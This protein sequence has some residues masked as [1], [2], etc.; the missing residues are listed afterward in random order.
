MEN[1]E[2]IKADLQKSIDEAGVALKTK[3]SNAEDL[4]QK[5]FDKADAVLKSL[6]GVLS[7]EDAQKMQSQL[8]KLD[9]AIQKSAVQK[10]VNEESFKD[11]FMKAYAPVQKEIERMKSAGERL[12]AP[13]TFEIQEKTVGTI[14]LAS[15]L[16]NVSSS[17]QVTI[18][19]FTGVVSP[20]RQR[21]LTYLQ[22]VSV[23]AIGTQYAVWVEEY[24]QEGVPVFIGEGIEK[25]Q[26][27]VQYKEQRAKVN[28]IGVHMKVTTEMLE[29]A[30][31][32]FSYI[33]SNGVKRV[34]TVI[35]NQLFNGNGT[36]PQLI[37]LIGK[38]T[39]FTGASMAGNVE[40]ATN[41][42]VIHGIIAQ[43]KAANGQVN[44]V[45]VE[46]GQYHVMLSEKDGD[47]QYILPAGVTF[48]AQGGLNA[49]GVRIIPTNALT[50]T[51]ADF[52]GGDLSVVNVRLRTGIQVAIGEAG[53][54]FIDNLKTV[55]IEQRLVQFI[56]A[57]DTQ[58][59]VK[60]TFSS[61]KTILE[62]T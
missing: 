44:G 27:D 48:D 12:K 51:S 1:L 40:S 45:F 16:A 38:A 2:T 35:E 59:L 29:D 22:N 9:I 49:W 37:G 10:Q 34:E 42:D 50:G 33:Q 14:S 43:V 56:S 36:D 26:L 6:D 18:S 15:T 52:V 39:A 4:A 7:K 60:G 5:A 21:L 19:E 13:I 24:D 47:K 3:A 46:T 8:D 32:L 17:S 31:Y 53:D 61:A 20:I 58:V 23:G 41:W 30:G 25:T 57:N 54:D 11:A 55:R 62:T 28:K